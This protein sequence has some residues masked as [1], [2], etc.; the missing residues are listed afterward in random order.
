MKWTHEGEVVSIR[1]HFLACLTINFQI[2]IVY[3]LLL[4]FWNEAE[5][6]VII[7]KVIFKRLCEYYFGHCTLFAVY[8][9][10]HGVSDNRARFHRQSQWMLLSWA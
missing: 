8:F 7:F 5:V 9:N 1:L 10:M 6:P 2:P 4:S 3:Q